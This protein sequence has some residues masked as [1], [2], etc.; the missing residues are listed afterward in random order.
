M[1][2]F[3]GRGDQG[4]KGIDKALEQRNLQEAVVVLG[5]SGAWFYYVCRLR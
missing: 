1:V 5:D 3:S 2:K 4:A